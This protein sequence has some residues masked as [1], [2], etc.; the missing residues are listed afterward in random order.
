MPSD[1]K[2]IEY[3]SEQMELAGII[4][5]KPMMG[6]YLLYCIGISI[7]LM[8]DNQ[9]FVKPM[10]SGRSFIGKAAENKQ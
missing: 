5:K 10:E 9:L 6:E 7:A 1:K 4:T 2:F 3:I 8:G